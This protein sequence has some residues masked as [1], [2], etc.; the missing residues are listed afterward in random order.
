MLCRRI[1]AALIAA[2]LLLGFGH[3]ITPGFHQAGELEW[4]EHC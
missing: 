4:C 1:A 2:T 3:A